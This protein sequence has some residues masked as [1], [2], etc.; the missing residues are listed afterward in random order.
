MNRGS[1]LAALA[2]IV[3]TVTAWGQARAGEEIRVFLFAGQSNM[4]GADTN[5]KEVERH[6]PFQGSMEPQEDV[7]YAY[8]LGR[9]TKSNGWTVLQPVDGRFGPEITFARSLKRHVDYP[10]AIIKDAWGGTTLVNDWDPDGGDE[11]SKKLYSRMIDQVRARLAELKAQGK[12]Y[13]IEAMMWH[14]GENDMFD[15]EGK[16]TY[17][18]N[19][20]NFIARIRTDLQVPRLKFFVGEISNKGVWGMDNRANVAKICVQQKAVVAAD[21]QVYFVPTSHLGFKVGRPVGLHYHFGTL[22]QLQ[23]GQ[24]YA[25]HFLAATGKAATSKDRSLS[26]SDMPKTKSVE[27]FVLGGQRNMEGE[28]AY[29]AEIE[30]FPHYADLLRNQP[31]L[32]QYSLGDVTSSRT[33]EPLGIVDYLG[34]FGPELSFGRAMRQY[35]DRS[36]GLAIYKFTHSGAQSLDWLP[37]GSEEKHRDLYQE[38][39]SGIERCRKDLTELGYQCDIPAVFW[40]CGEND[41]ALVWMADKY[42]GRLK[43]FIDATRR[44][45]KLPNLKWIIT[46]QPI[47][48]LS[49]AGN[50]KLYDLNKDLEAMAAAD[51]NI[52][53]VKTSHLPHRLVLFGTEGVLFLGDEMAQAWSTMAG[54][55]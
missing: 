2:T 11:K 45:L 27:L 24:A 22:G 9:D 48:P 21:P 3:V 10:I 18:K 30:Q 32:Y 44:D 19:L 7:L 46:E 38:W 16:L 53:F 20:T 1:L 40:H 26:R 23:H 5:Q 55:Q 4:E 28:E 52:R 51:P 41:R 50:G 14:Q 42:A 43:T 49:F 13:R 54:S 6:P 35:V 31:V 25:R 29:V 36:H 37:Q 17:E 39:I 34:T 12:R 47:L 15:R 8:N 33:W